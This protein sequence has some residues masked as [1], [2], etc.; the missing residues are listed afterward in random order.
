MEKGNKCHFCGVETKYGVTCDSCFEEHNHKIDKARSHWLYWT[1]WW[2]GLVEAKWAY[3]ILFLPWKLFTLYQGLAYK[4][5]I[6]KSYPRGWNG[7]YTTEIQPF[8]IRNY[9]LDGWN[10]SMSHVWIQRGINKRRKRHA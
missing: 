10:S 1:D 8:Y 4:Y 9:Y 3:F 7:S 2:F 5:I 6:K